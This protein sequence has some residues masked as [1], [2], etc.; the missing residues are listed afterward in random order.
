MLYSKRIKLP[1]VLLIET[2]LIITCILIS[3]G[4][5]GLVSGTQSAHPA[6]DAFTVPVKIDTYGN[7]WHGYLAFGLWDFPYGSTNF[8]LTPDNYLVVMTTNG[9]LLDL[10]TTKGQTNLGPSM[11]GFAGVSNPTYAPV[12]YLGQDTLMYEC[13][14]RTQ[15]PTFGICKTNVTT[16]FPNVYGHHDMIFNPV[17]G[18]FSHVEK[19]RETD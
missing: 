5:T 6:A 8:S 1:R 16:D 12:K 3:G 9:Q 14:T 19:L 4:V 15:R 2:A 13:R 17:T 11:S 10:Q 7:A 18:N